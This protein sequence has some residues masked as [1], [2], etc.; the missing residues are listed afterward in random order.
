MRPSVITKLRDFVPITELT[1]EQAYRLAEL[2]AARFRA[3]TN[4]RQPRLPSEAISELQHVRVKHLSPLPVSGATA[5]SHGQWVILLRSSEPH[6]RQ[7]FS[8]AHEFK[9][10]LDHRFIDVLYE[11][12]PAGQRHDFIEQICDYFAGCLLVPRPTL[13]SLWSSGV[14]DV[15]ELASRFDVSQQAIQTRLAQVGLAAR[16]PRCGVSNLDWLLLP[17]R[18]ADSSSASYNRTVHPLWADAEPEGVPV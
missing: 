11:R 13:R 9:H 8:L 4:N 18:S 5:W 15:G 12:I 1:R 6:G 16:Q 2:Q 17:E 10:I 3:L 14:H 7:R